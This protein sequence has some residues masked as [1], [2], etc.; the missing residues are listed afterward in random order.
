[1]K[2]ASKAFLA[3]LERARNEDAK[4]KP[5][6]SFCESVAATGAGKW[7]LRKLTKVGP[8]YGGGIDTPSLCGHVKTGW[9]IEVELTEHH[10]C[11]STCPACLAQAKHLGLLRAPAGPIG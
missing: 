6:L 10:L 11:K 3:A 5:K 1:M 9:D 7:H 4:P 8:K 2:R